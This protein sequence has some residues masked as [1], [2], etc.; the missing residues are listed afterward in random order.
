ML[1][2][3]SDLEDIGAQGMHKS[4]LGVAQIQLVFNGEMP[5]PQLRKQATDLF[6]EFPPSV[7]TS[8]MHN[9]LSTDTQAGS[10]VK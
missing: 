1:T 7:I 3:M 2:Q 10:I 9:P 8:F 4:A 6:M 5:V